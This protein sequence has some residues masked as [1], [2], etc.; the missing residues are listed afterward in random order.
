M[1]GAVSDAFAAAWSAQ[2]APVALALI[3]LTAPS[4]V[5]LRVGTVDCITPDGAA[6]EAGLACEPIRD[7]VEFLGPGPGPVTAGFSLAKRV[8]SALAVRI[9][10]ALRLWQFKNASVTL[11]LW[12]RSLTSEPPAQVFGGVID[13]IDSGNDGVRF[14]ALQYRAWTKPIPALTIDKTSFPD[15]AEGTEG[16]PVPIIYG[17]HTTPQLRGA[18]AGLGL[19]SDFE[20]AG[21]ARGV[22]P[23][24]VGDTGTGAAKVRLLAAS[25]AIMDI[26]GAADSTRLFMAGADRFL[27]PMAT[28]GVTETL[29]P[30]AYADVDDDTLSISYP[31]VPVDVRTG[32]G[33]NSALNPRRAFDVG[34]ETS[35][36]TLDQGAGYTKLDVYLPSPSRFGQIS[37][38]TIVACVSGNAANANNIQIYGRDSGSSSATVSAAC[39]STTPFIVSG[40]YPTGWWNQNWAFG[41]NDGALGYGG[42]SGNTISLCVDFTGGATNK[43]RV[44]WIVLYATVKPTRNELVPAVDKITG[45]RI[46]GRPTA[47]HFDSIQPYSVRDAVPAVY[48]LDGSFYAN[49]KGYADDGSGTYTGSA[50]ALIERVPDILRHLLAV[51][52]GVSSFE[53]GAAAHG[54]FVLARS[55]LRAGNPADFKA[56]VH[57]GQR[58]MLQEAAQS[59][60]SQ[61]LCSFWMDRFD[62]KWRVEVWKPGAPVTYERS[63]SWYDVG[64]FTAQE[65]SLT[66]LR[67]EVRVQYLMD[68]YKGRCLAEAFI[69]QDGSSQGWN[70]PLIRDQRLTVANGANDKLDYIYNTGVPATTAETLTP[71]TYVPIDLAQHL[72]DLVR[73][74]V[75]GST[76]YKFVHF[77]H[78]VDIKAGLNDNVEFEYDGTPC[79]GTLSAAAYTMDD[80]AIA[81]AREMNDAAG[82][83]G[84]IGCAYDH[85]TNKFTVTSS[86]A[87][88]LIY[89]ENAAATG[90]S[91]CWPTFGFRMD[92][93]PAAGTSLA[94]AYGVY[95]ERF[96]SS[97]NGVGLQYL[98]GTGANLATSC[99]S[100]LGARQADTT[101]ASPG[102]LHWSADYSRGDRERESA[103]RVAAYGATGDHTIRAEWLRDEDAAVS[104][105]DRLWDMTSKPPIGV[106]FNSFRMVG[107]RRLQTFPVSS[108]FNAHV[109]FPRYGSDGSWAGKVLRALGV[110]Q[111]MGPT[112]QTEVSAVEA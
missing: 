12:D 82:L 85:A 84:V 56:A 2:R 20:N 70:L 3:S 53:T 103:T 80:A 99:G 83:D 67:S 74:R 6:W 49:L 100:L 109:A 98:F 59:L 48:S 76:A 93:L 61:S 5:T 14:T 97:G 17:A 73:T 60:A 40:T 22:V 105:R 54:S 106:T 23:L 8:Y 33:N 34:D 92:S 31:I 43:A 89:D 11:Y 101:A 88:V 45:R 66:N 107:L 47:P 42:T 65:G 51:H 32:G 16:T 79:V 91:L 96:W 13:D 58:M 30:T 44:Y 46:S 71:G 24:I 15:A 55:V 9:D 104:L 4:A 63:L 68:W 112:F 69:K 35:Y 72:Q 37:S 95:S 21:G 77:G 19:E 102:V 41:V 62:N 29:T 111:Y 1:I 90:H 28:S 108:D 38:V 75:G 50:G 57:I 81:L 27:C 36:A 25:H 18:L 7:E 110:T 78:G 94:G 86:G 52:G 10:A 26:Y 39:T 64:S 87:N